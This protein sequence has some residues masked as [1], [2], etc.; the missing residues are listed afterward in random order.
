MIEN[1]TL[2]NFID[3]S[4]DE[5]KM[6][7]LWR[8]HPS[9]KMMMYNSEDILLENHLRFIDNLN[10]SID[11]LYF[12]AKQ[13]D[14]YIGVIDFTNITNESSEFGLY[15]N[16]DLKGYGK[17]LLSSIVEYG[18]DTLN[19]KLLIAEVFSTNKKAISL[20]KE[21][22]FKEISKKIVSNKEV[23]CMELKN[24]N[25]KGTLCVK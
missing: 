10:D 2:V 16:I 3:L 19:L 1:I 22:N 13:D 5:K 14:K 25:Y 9:V 8:N 24:D 4:D 18:F 15:T 12:L 11:K 23:I 21:F 6:V 20:Y 17:V 7:L